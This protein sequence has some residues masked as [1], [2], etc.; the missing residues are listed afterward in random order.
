M[1]KTKLELEIEELT[2]EKSR[3]SRE[4][5]SL[6]TQ[7]EEV[8]SR[9][10]KI[11]EDKHKKSIAGE[12]E[13]LGFTI[14]GSYPYCKTFVK[15][16]L[17]LKSFVDKGEVTMSLDGLGFS[18]SE[19]KAVAGPDTGA[20]DVLRTI[21]N[22]LEKNKSRRITEEQEEI[23]RIQINCA[24]KVCTLDSLMRKIDEITTVFD[25]HEK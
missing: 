10:G 17:R 19:I 25:V 21:R 8:K 1:K 23:K 11:E 18:V 22:G 15:D 2:A 24:N 7:L 3:L 12:F 6:D 20:I 13:S 14:L 4:I 16:G 5:S 9:L